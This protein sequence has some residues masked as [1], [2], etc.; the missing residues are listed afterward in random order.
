MNK[1]IR[2]AAIAIAF[3]VPITASATPVTWSFFETGCTNLNTGGDCTPPQPLVI[4]TLALTGPTSAGSAVWQPAGF[5]PVTPPVFTGDSFAFDLP[6]PLFP[7]LTPA[8]TGA[9]QCSG[10][11]QICDFDLSWSESN[12]HLD[13]VSIALDTFHSDIGNP[14][15]FGL[16]GGLIGSDDTFGSCTNAQCRVTGF[17]QSNLVVPE[18]MSAVLLMTGLIGAC[19]AFATR[20]DRPTPRPPS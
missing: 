7:L 16:T 1:L 4:A 12:G 17:W 8:F 10:G 18:P 6:L 11:N 2:F 15:P 3:A 5:P 20:G 13:A 14:A 9:G 19:L